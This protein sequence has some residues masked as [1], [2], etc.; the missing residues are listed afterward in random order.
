MHDHENP[1]NMTDEDLA[2]TMSVIV[3]TME[4]D[5]DIGYDLTAYD[6]LVFREVMDRFDPNVKKEVT[7]GTTKLPAK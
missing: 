1:A 3:E 6:I 5:V 2:G 7:N 4:D